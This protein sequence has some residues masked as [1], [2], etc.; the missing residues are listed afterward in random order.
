M[1]AAL[2]RGIH[3]VPSRTQKLSPSAPMVLG[4]RCPGRVGRRRQLM[5]TPCHPND[6]RAF[7]A[8]GT[9]P[10]VGLHRGRRRSRRGSTAAA[11]SRVLAGEATPASTPDRDAAT[12]GAGPTCSCREGCPWLRSYHETLHK[13]PARRIVAFESL[14]T[15]VPADSGEWP[16]PSGVWMLDFVRP[17]V[18]LRGA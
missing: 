7:L 3:L 9:Q 1:L 15:S 17:S 13:P 8:S 2:A 6:G 12:C 16:G 14:Y 18:G 5:R 10:L 4:R 11:A